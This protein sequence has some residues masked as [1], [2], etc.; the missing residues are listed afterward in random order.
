MLTSLSN[1]EGAFSCCHKTIS[2]EFNLSMFEVVHT[3]A[4]S[5][6]KAVNVILAG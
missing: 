6:M 3:S 2:N 4:H 1:T 5:H